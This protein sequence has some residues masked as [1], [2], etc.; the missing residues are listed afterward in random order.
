MAVA[1]ANPVTE[2]NLLFYESVLPVFN[3]A[4][5]LLQQEDPNIYLHVVV[6]A[7]GGFF[8]ELLSK[9]ASLQVIKAADDITS[10]DFQ[11]PVN[12]LND[13]AI[14]IGMVT[15]QRLGKLLNEGDICPTDE[16]KFYAGAKAFCVDAASPAL[17]KLPFDNGVRENARFLNFERREE[18]TCTFDFIEFFVT[19]TWTYF[20]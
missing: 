8:K 11:N 9:F 18:Y 5:L 2:V 3:H 12:H 20:R 4:N 16:K 7:L 14:T 15:K 19:S 13:H 10:A 1:F 6:D 17:K